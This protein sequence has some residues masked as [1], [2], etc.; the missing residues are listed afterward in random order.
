MTSRP[1]STKKRGAN[2]SSSK[3]PEAKPCSKTGGAL[4]ILSVFVSDEI[5]RE[6]RNMVQI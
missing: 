4:N 3:L 6:L 5:S 1:W 2:A